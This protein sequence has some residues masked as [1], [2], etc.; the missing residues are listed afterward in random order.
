M[1]HLAPS[2][3]SLQFVGKRVLKTMVMVLGETFSVHDRK[4][5]TQGILKEGGYHL[6]VSQTEIKL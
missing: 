1:L 6:W 5:R 2:P 3:S 4:I